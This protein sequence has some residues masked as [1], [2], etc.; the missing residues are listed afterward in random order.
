M[1]RLLAR[2]LAATFVL[3]TLLGVATI[4]T[5]TAAELPAPTAGDPPLPPPPPPPP[6]TL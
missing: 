5:A 2:V 6:P 4:G 3:S 1:N